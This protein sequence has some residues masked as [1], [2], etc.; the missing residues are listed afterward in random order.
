MPGFSKIRG[1]LLG[2]PIS[3]FSVGFYSGVPLFG[4]TTMF[5]LVQVLVSHTVTRS[6]LQKN[7]NWVT[8]LSLKAR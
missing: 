1:N 6:P 3:T 5:S 2:V 7:M 4:E 8:R